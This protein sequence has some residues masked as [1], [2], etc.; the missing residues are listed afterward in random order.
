MFDDS[1]KELSSTSQI[2]RVT[3]KRSL[4]TGIEQV[5]AGFTQKE[6]DES[7]DDDQLFFI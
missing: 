5:V 4:I 2:R 7:S 1:D 6:N 3:I